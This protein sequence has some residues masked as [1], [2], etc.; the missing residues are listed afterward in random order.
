[1]WDVN[2]QGAL[3]STAEAGVGGGRSGYLNVWMWKVS[4]SK[5]WKRFQNLPALHKMKICT[6]LNTGRKWKEMRIL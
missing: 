5:N 1:M 4:K 2:N 6:S 3:K